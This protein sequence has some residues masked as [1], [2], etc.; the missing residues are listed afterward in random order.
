MHGWRRWQDQGIDKQVKYLKQFATPYPHYV[1]WGGTLLELIGGVFLIVGALT[2]LVAA[3]LVAEQVL[4][5]AYTSWYK[6]LYLT[7]G[8]G[9]FQGGYE[10]SVILGL[11]ALLFVVFGAGRVSVDRLFKRSPPNEDPTDSGKQ[12]SPASSTQSVAGR[13]TG[14]P[15][16]TDAT[17]RS[18]HTSDSQPPPSRL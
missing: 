15:T 11:L 16:G 13:Q 17:S 1:A 6:G 12:S 9:S 3:A 8:S 5:I 4:I 14:S 10:Y 7:D 2:P 18:E